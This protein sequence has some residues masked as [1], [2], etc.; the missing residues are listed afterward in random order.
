MAAVQIYFLMIAI[1][2]Q[3]PDVSPLGG[4]TTAMT[5]CVVLGFTAIKEA[6]ED[7]KRHKLDKEVNNTLTGPPF[8]LCDVLIWFLLPPDV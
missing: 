4:G 7:R 8:C 2:Q 1:L 5:L 3:I 6:F